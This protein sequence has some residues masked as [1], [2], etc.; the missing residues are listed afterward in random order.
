MLSTIYNNILYS[1]I[2]PYCNATLT[3]TIS[4]FKSCPAPLHIT[5]FPADS[6]IEIYAPI[7]FDID[8]SN[9][10]I[11]Q[12]YKDNT[13]LFIADLSNLKDFSYKGLLNYLTKLYIF[14]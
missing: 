3:N 12:C 1:N 11:I 13:P 10:T 14:Q 2:C 4:N 6:L 7:N 9:P 8:L 5:I